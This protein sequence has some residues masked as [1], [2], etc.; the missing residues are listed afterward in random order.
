MPPSLVLTARPELYLRQTAGIC[1]R[2][3]LGARRSRAAESHGLRGLCYTNLGR[4]PWIHE[5]MRR[6]AFWHVDHVG[7]SNDWQPA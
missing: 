5:S 7:I 4:L 1:Q 3:D 2:S 6:L